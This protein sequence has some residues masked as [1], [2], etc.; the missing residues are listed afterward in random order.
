LVAVDKPASPGLLPL[1]GIRIVEASTLLAGPLAAALLSEWG[2]SVIKIEGPAGDPM[3]DWPPFA[4]GRSVTW[5]SVARNK[6]LVEL[7]FHRADDRDVLRQLLADADVFITNFRVP[8]LRG[9]KLDYDDLRDLNPNLVMLHVTGFG[10][11]GPYRERPGFARIAEAFSGLTY[12]TGRED[13]E[14]MFPGYPIGDAVCG[15][16]GA[17]SVLLALRAREQQGRGGLVDLALYEPMLRLLDDLAPGFVNAG[18]IKKRRG[19]VQDHSVPNG[20]YPTKDDAYIVLP[21]STTN[22]WR[23][24]VDLMDEPSLEAFDTLAS[25]VENRA[26][27]DEAI[28]AFTLRHTVDELIEMTAARE[29]ACGRVYSA[30]DIA[31]DPQIA[32]RGNLMRVPDESGDGSLVVTAPVPVSDLFSSIVRWTGRERAEPTPS[33]DADTSEQPAP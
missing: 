22:M 26:L 5:A 31:E 11:T 19:N 28:R 23:R 7:D 1:D 12:I 10:R 20:L 32:A 9:W 3:R 13:E 24:M 18:V 6:D 14:P 21:V 27:I 16:Y 8:T 4:D 30:A 15:L 33:G 29:I 2:A 17:Y 25:R